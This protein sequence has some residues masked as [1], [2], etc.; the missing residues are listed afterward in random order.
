MDALVVDTPDHR[1]TAET[2][3]AAIDAD[4]DVTDVAA[5]VCTSGTTNAGIIDDLAGVGA[6]AQERD[7]WFHV[8]G[9]YGGSGIFARS[10]RAKYDGLELADSFILDPHKWLFTPFDCCALLYRNPEL[11]RATHTQDASYLDVIHGSEGEWN[12]T[13]YA[14]H[15]TRRAR[16]LPLWFSMAVYGLD[17]YREAI[18]VAVTLARETAVLIRATP[19][20]ELIREPDLGVVLF[21][22]VGW[23]PEQYDAWAQALLDEEIAFIPPTKWEGE[24]VGRFA[25]LHPATTMDLVRQILARTE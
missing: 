5:V 4:P 16:G 2:V 9:A 18:E 1:M 25:F 14:Y 17:A 19:H 10:L 21:R 12:P 13:D 3:R 8:D 6:L 7:W 20:L 22:R 24:T 15:L 23:R 11:A